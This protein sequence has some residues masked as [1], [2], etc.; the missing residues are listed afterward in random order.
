MRTFIAVEL[1]KQI[2]NQIHQQQQSLA[3]DLDDPPIRWVKPES[4]HL[5]LKFLGE[6]PQPKA[7]QI[8]DGLPAEAGHFST[9]AIVVA[10]LGCFPDFNRPRVVW[11]GLDDRGGTIKDLQ[12][13]LDQWLV[14]LGF[15]PEKRGFSPH[16]TIG[17]V[18]RRVNNQQRRKLGDR[19]RDYKVPQLGEFEADSVHLFRSDLKPTGAV[20]TR[21]ATARLKGAHD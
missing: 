14:K 2:Q 18:H 9:T 8:G 11:V 3:Q 12:A 13:H 15:D 19:I 10:G 1:P 6:I 4:I 21:L 7:Q 20:Y 5:T 17:R 16:L